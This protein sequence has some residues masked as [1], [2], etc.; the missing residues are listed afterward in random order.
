MKSQK[1]HVENIKKRNIKKAAYINYL[2]KTSGYNQNLIAAELKVTPACV[3]RV[4]NGVAKSS[5][6]ENWL[7]K[8]LKFEVMYD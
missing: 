8:H 6:V 3:C 5:R 2:L 1:I 4:I 7:K